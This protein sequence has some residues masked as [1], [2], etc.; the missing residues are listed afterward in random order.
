MKQIED[1]FI[2]LVVLSLTNFSV[3][4][5]HFKIVTILIGLTN[6]Q[7]VLLKLPKKSVDVVL[8]ERCLPWLYEFVFGVDKAKINFTVGIQKNILYVYIRFIL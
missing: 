3:L 6:S 5:F 8:L 4:L 2:S 7:I 1:L